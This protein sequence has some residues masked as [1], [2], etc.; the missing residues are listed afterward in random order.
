MIVVVEVLIV[1]YDGMIDY[2]IEVAVV[3]IV[4]K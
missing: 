3:Y 2:M 4:F 1:S